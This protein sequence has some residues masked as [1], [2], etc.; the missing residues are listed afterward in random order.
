MHESLA[1]LTHPVG[2]MYKFVWWMF[3]HAKESNYT[4]FM[5]DSTKSINLE[6]VGVVHGFIHES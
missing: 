5:E 4:L 1:T 2:M 3:H 6:G